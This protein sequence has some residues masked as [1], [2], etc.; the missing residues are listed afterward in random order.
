MRQWSTSSFFGW[1]SKIDIGPLIGFNITAWLVMRIAPYAHITMKGSIT[2][3]LDVFT[4][5]KFSS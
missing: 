4:A 5:G 2:C 1:L 3:S